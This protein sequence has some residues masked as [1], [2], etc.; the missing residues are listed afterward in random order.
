MIK[1]RN[2]EQVELKD[3]FILKIKE[4]F[5]AK[6][7][8]LNNRD[9]NRRSSSYGYRTRMP[10]DYKS[11]EAKILAYCLTEPGWQKFLTRMKQLPYKSFESIRSNGEI[12][13]K[14][15]T[16]ELIVDVPP[17]PS[18]MTPGK[19]NLG[20]YA[21]Y[22]P[23]KSL[24]GSQIDAIHFIP[25]KLPVVDRDWDYHPRHLHHKA[26]PQSGYANPLT[27]RPNTC[28]GNFGSMVIMTM[29][30]GDIPELYRLL[31]MYLS[32]QNVNSPL[33]YWG[34]LSRIYERIKDNE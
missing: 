29:Q 34:D 17:R 19:Y 26:H 5:S 12:Y 32:I 31:H 28:W 8:Q 9:T 2:L 10:N 20:Q 27:Y 13:I 33:T 11:E 14:A 15:T 24:V 1:I 22:I 23:Y 6:L 30:V 21:I 3:T 7:D 16:K 18:Y 4:Y 25:L